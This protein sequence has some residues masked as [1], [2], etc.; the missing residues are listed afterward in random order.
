MALTTEQRNDFVEL[1]VSNVP[2]NAFIEVV[3]EQGVVVDYDL[4]RKQAPDELTA[5]RRYIAG[6]VVDTYDGKNR[7]SQLAA[8]LYRRVYLDDYLAPKLAAY[9]AQADAAID[10]AAKQAAIVKRANTMSSRQLREFLSENEPKICLIMA[11]NDAPAADPPL[12]LGTGFLVGPDTVLTA[13][14]TLKDHIAEG[15]QLNASPGRCCAVFDYYDGDP[16][17]DFATI[18]ASCRVVEF[19]KEWLL[20]SKEDM[21]KDGLF[22]DP[23]QDQLKLLPTRLDFA[24]IKLAEAVGKQTRERTGGARRSWIRLA[25][26]EVP[27]RNDDRIIIPQHPNGYHQR[28]D[29]GRFSE[30]D[31]AFDTSKTRFRYDTET[32]QGTSGAPCFDH[33]FKLVGMHNAS[34]RPANI[35]LK[36][37]QAI[38][39]EPIHAV[40]AA[41]PDRT[42]ADAA[43]VRLWNTSTTNQPRV[44]LGRTILLDW[45]ERG[46]TE[47]TSEAKQRVYAATIKPEDRANNTG[48]GKRF[49]I[50]ILTSA[51][52]GK[53]EPIVLLGTGRDSLPDSVPDLVRAIGFHLGIDKARLDT[54]PP[55]PSAALPTEAPNADKLRRWASQDV[56]AWFD[57][58]IAKW[59]EEEFDEVEDAKKRVALAQ[60]NNLPPS[61]QDVELAR[62]AAPRK[63]VRRRWPIA[64]VAINLAGTTVSEELQDLLAGLIVRPAESTMP[65]QLKRLR[66]LF[67][68][69]AP[70]FLS[71][72]QYTVEELDPRQID[73]EDIIAATRLL[74][75]SMAF[76]LSDTD[77]E[78]VQKM[79]ELVATHP[80]AVD[81]NQRM[82][83][84][85]GTLFPNLHELLKRLGK[86]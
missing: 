56:P 60:Q 72:D 40:I 80:S 32:D 36:K 68:G 81:P 17:I 4:L 86:S 6:N 28:I 5:A 48:F 11:A 70:D 47:T 26:P 59:G 33:R 84:L 38:R 82:T 44:I 51:R 31:S 9:A 16:L 62:E 76:N 43:P 29:F 19:H 75:E 61:P 74:A 79:I 7:I 24:L 42:D 67:V 39:I 18:P 54:I 41:V 34:F 12:R 23:D 25:V 53:A 71:T 22:R 15:K 83:F 52:R 1:L 78:I 46:R 45:I 85:Q 20:A 3:R 30:Q 66:W 63:S 64:W 65:R 2:S 49:T 77:V 13:Y 21:P 37:N 10:D 73:T 14:H 58:V 55:R 50:E 8:G 27:L 57:D 69:D 35:D